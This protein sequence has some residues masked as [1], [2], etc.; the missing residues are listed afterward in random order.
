MFL[1]GRSNLENSDETYT[2]MRNCAGAAPSLDL[3]GILALER[4]TYLLL[5]KKKKNFHNSFHMLME[6]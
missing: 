5:I 1:E 2:D 6:K 4:T 3:N